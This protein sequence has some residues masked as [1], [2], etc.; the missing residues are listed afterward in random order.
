MT[1]NNDAILVTVGPRKELFHICKKDC[2]LTVGAGVVW[3]RQRLPFL[4]PRY[5]LFLALESTLI[6]NP[7]SD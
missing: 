2:V 5:S 1:V 7:M 3:S 4:C 6:G